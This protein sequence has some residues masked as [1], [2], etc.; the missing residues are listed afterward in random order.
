MAAASHWAK[1]APDK[2]IPVPSVVPEYTD[3]SKRQKVLNSSP[4]H[5]LHALAAPQQDA[6]TDAITIHSLLSTNELKETFQFNF[7]MD[8]ELLLSLLP[9]QFVLSR[10]RLNLIVGDDIVLEYD[11]KLLDQYN[12]SQTVVKLPRYGSHHTKMMIN[13]FCDDTIEIVIM[14]S[15]ITKVD[16]IM[17]QMV[18]RS[19]LLS[20]GKTTEIRGLK[21][22]D[23]M[24]NYLARYETTKLLKL[25]HKLQEYNF[26]PV[27]VVLI[28]STPGTY[29]LKDKEIYGYGK[30]YNELKHLDSR[31]CNILAQVSSIASPISQLKGQVSSLFTHLL[32]PLIV[33]RSLLPP[34]TESC[35]SHQKR[36]NYKPWIIFPTAKDIASCSV[37]FGVGQ[38]I[39]F[40]YTG[41]KRQVTQF[42]DIKKYLCKW[43][44]G[45]TTGRE[46]NPPH[47]KLYL[48][49][50]GDDFKTL[51]WAL[52]GS[53][54]LSKQAWGGGKGFGAWFDINN[55][56]VSSYELSVLVVPE[57]G[58]LTPVYKSDYSTSLNP[59]R[60]PFS[61]PPTKYTSDD[62]PWSTLVNFGD[63]KDTLG[64]T[65]EGMDSI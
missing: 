21:F 12:I 41:N 27:K 64:Q 57:S 37:G 28:A 11:P 63:L 8:L 46:R 62:Q 56:E 14:S 51:K 50:N 18:W 31:G 13:M 61:L 38:L 59:I 3:T 5:L 35:Q 52:M 7:A 54:N 30:L 29:S 34:G 43:N 48:C 16:S 26:D 42:N 40:N 1:R 2:A 19:G 20:K 24:K 33:S 36:F 49:D 22:Q 23:D 45:N 44:T 17:T 55:Y 65:Y 9:P 60:M 25:L 6:N 4:I 32:C 58:V 15:N 53:H 10:G 39:H 47:V